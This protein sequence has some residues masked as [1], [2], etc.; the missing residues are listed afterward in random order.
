MHVLGTAGHVDHGKST[1]IRVLTNIDPDRLPEE[2]RR[3]MTIDLGFAWWEV[4]PGQRVGVVDVPGHKDFTRNLL[5]GLSSVDAVLLVIAANEGWMPQTEEHLRYVEMLGIRHG[6]VVLTKIDL[7]DDREWLELVE[8]DIHERLQDSCLQGA[9]LVRVSAKDGRGL[10]A[11]AA[12]V[13]ELL[14]RLPGPRDIG[15]P[16]LWVDRVFG[17]SGTGT[18]VTGRL[19]DGTLRHG[20][21]VA[22]HPGDRRGRVKKLECFKERHEE[23]G[24]GARLAVNLTGIST[25]DV[26]RGSLLVRADVPVQ[27]SQILDVQLRVA[28]SYGRPVR[29]NLEV[30]VYLGTLETVAHL[31]PFD[32]D[33]APG[34][35]GFAQLRFQEDVFASVGDRFVVRA[36][37]ALLG[38]GVV[39]NVGAR[40]YR[41]KERM[42]IGSLLAT[43]ASMRLDDMVMAEVR[44]H[45]ACR[46]R[47]ILL[48]SHVAQEEVSQV[49]DRL[50]REG[51]LLR[52]GAHVVDP[53]F[54]QAQKRALLEALEDKYAQYPLREFFSQA[55]LHGQLLL[56]REISKT[57]VEELEAEGRIVRSGTQIALPGYRLPDQLEAVVQEVYEIIKQEKPTRQELKGRFENV[58]VDEVV[59]YLVRKEMVTELPGGILLDTALFTSMK[60][61]IVDFLRVHGTMS[62]QQVRDQLGLTRKYILPLLAKL[63]EDHVTRRVGDL[64]VLFGSRVNVDGAEIREPEVSRSTTTS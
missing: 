18:V 35:T 11:L 40:R 64:R 28:L 36:G 2:K 1:L 52:V 32:G 12:T 46:S 16:R 51:K 25:E 33:M 31:H 8:E 24:P 49:L 5:A 42:R 50:V 60:Q 29:K 9:P 43:K 26:H 4:A 6:V 53:D 44:Q 20:D 58:D 57:L 47:D 63:D 10:P 3:E 56:P 34:D 13:Q 48:Y 19:L 45:G 55:D 7:V 27:A 15:K 30:K 41:R 17:S 54:W 21:M 23:V 62:I 61:A 37:R 14:G 59:G 22:V 38:G 39:L